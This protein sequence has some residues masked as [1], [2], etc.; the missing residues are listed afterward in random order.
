LGFAAITLKL[1]FA[2]LMGRLTD[3]RARTDVKGR[4]RGG[5]D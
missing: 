3:S 1:M 4:L 5:Q 2:W